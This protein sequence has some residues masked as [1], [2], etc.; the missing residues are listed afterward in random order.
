MQC[1]PASN[2][3]Y[4]NNTNNNLAY[5]MTRIMYVKGTL[6]ASLTRPSASGPNTASPLCVRF[7]SVERK[8]YMGKFLL[9]WNGRKSTNEH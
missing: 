5:R 1:L 7:L 8:Q 3:Q 4:K 9:S 6:K 2:G